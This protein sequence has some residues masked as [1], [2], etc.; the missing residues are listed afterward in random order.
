MRTQPGNALGFQCCFKVYVHTCQSYSRCGSFQAVL[1]LSYA[2]YNM[3]LPRL[4]YSESGAEPLLPAVSDNRATDNPK[5]MSSKT[6]ASDDIFSSNGESLSF[7]TEPFHR[8]GNAAAA[9]RNSPAVQ[10]TEDRLMG[11]V[12][13]NSD[14]E[15][16]KYATAAGNLGMSQNSTRFISL[17]SVNGN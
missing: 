9:H 1:E 7:T 17:N 10:S 8:F 13:A 3:S 2:S 11:G 12:D 14:P 4:L 15:V 6:D 5:A 16:A